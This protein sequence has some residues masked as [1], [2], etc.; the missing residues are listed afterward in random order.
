MG[1]SRLQLN[2]QEAVNESA[3]ASR[4]EGGDKRGAS[5]D[6]LRPSAVC[7]ASD[8]GTSGSDSPWPM[9]T[10]IAWTATGTG[11]GN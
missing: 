10:G 11:C 2:V 6:F 1:T 9:N 5:P 8:T 7:R 4:Q 3:E